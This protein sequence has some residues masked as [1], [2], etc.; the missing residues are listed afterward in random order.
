MVDSYLE[1]SMSRTIIR[2]AL[3]AI[4]IGIGW[5]AGRAQPSQPH[6]ELVI[7]APAGETTVECRRG[8]TLAW[9]ERGVNPAS[10]PVPTF[11]FACGVAGD[12][13]CT[14]GRI[15]GWTAP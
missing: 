8:C 6:F 9:T 13:R 3:A 11:T 2:I 4:L 15:G 10:T 12:G 14:S 7:K 1:A 5:S